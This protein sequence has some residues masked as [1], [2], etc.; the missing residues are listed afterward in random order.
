VRRGAA[1]FSPD[2]VYAAFVPGPMVQLCAQ[3]KFRV[4]TALFIY[5]RRK[6]FG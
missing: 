6:F 3:G 5:L 4:R 1:D 2:G